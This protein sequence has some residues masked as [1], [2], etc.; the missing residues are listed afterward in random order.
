VLLL[1]EVADSSL[2]FDRTVKLDLYARSGII[3]YW[4]VNVIDAEVEVHR[5][6]LPSGAYRENTVHKGG[7]SIEP[8]AFPGVRFV[9]DEI[10]PSA[11]K[12]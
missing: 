9:V 7:D 4:I 8:L 5:G 2:E 3:E 6:P 10:V 11:G 1:V 12:S